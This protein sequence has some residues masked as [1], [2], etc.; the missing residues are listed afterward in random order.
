MKVKVKFNTS[1]V[2]AEQSLSFSLNQ[3]VEVE[4][5]LVESYIENGVAELVEE[6]A[7]K[8]TPVKTKAKATA[9]KKAE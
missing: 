1:V 4:K 3:V 6:V 8:T 7:E 9:S 5:S 2:F